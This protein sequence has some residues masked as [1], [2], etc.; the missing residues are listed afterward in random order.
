MSVDAAK[1]HWNAMFVETALRAQG[2]EPAP[3][4]PEKIAAAMNAAYAA[5]RL[6]EGLPFECDPTGYALALERCKAG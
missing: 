2:I 1:Q 5:D 3:G 6:R 4:R